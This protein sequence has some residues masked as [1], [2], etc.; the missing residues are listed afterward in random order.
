VFAD[1]PADL[2][3]SIWQLSVDGYSTAYEG[4][5]SQ[6]FTV[7][8][9]YRS[10]TPSDPPAP[11]QPP[12]SPP[13]EPSVPVKPSQPT[14]PQTGVQLWPLWL[15]LVAGVLLIALGLADLYLGRKKS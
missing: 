7:I 11:P 6:G 14:I 15:L 3:Y 8:N 10:Q 4:S 12:D 5:A 2:A 9:T 13:Y 1:V